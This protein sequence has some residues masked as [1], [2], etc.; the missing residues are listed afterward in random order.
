MGAILEAAGTSFDNVVKTTL[1]LAEI[2]DFKE[3]NAVYGISL[4]ACDT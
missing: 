3:V 4:V 1:L 2:E